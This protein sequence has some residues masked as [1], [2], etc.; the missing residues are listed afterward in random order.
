LTTT[1]KKFQQAFKKEIKK[2][3]SEIN[4][5]VEILKGKKKRFVS[6]AENANRRNQ[7]N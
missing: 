7:R 5:A 4:E 3:S 1:G 6:T 2:N